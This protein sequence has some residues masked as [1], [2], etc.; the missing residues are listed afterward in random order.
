MVIVLK[1]YFGGDVIPSP[2]LVVFADLQTFPQSP[3]N[4]GDWDKPSEPIKQ[5]LYGGGQPMLI[6]IAPDY[7]GSRILGFVFSITRASNP[8]LHFGNPDILI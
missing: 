4:S 8:Q 5:A 1:Q 6:P 7:E 2:Q 3:M